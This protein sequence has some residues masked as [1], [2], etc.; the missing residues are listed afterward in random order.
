V[1]GGWLPVL[2]GWLPVLGGWLPVLGGW[3]PVLV[4]GGGARERAANRRV[5]RSKAVMCSLIVNMSPSVPL[6]HV[7]EPLEQ[8]IARVALVIG[9]RVAAERE[10]RRWTLR[11]LAKRA[12]VSPGVVHGVEAGRIASLPTY[13][14]LARALGLELDVLLNDPR[15]AGRKSDFVHS[16]MGELEAARLG[17]G[18]FGVGV[19]EPYQHFQYAGR[20]DIAAWDLARRT[21]LVT[22]NR[23]RFPDFQDLA[24][25]WNAKRAYFPAEFAKRLGL[26][27]GWRSVTHAMVV[28][29]TAEAVEDVQA[30]R[31]SI[32]ALCPDPPDAFVRWWAGTPP[33]AGTFATALVLDPAP[34]RGQQMFVSLAEGLSSE[35]RYRGYAQLAARLRTRQ[36][37]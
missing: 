13:V 8:A 6:A 14:R 34:R 28:A 26:K 3:L 32:R 4:A 36:R 2:G 37:R 22:E 20:V 12:N 16:A 17:E 7:S 33:V 1:L 29:W 30:R 27:Y 35:P 19:D 21:L 25:A 18:G 23:T 24:G 9:L 31:A 15:R 11:E 5:S 10:R